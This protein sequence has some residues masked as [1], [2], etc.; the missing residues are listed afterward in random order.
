MRV[1]LSILDARLQLAVYTFLD[2]SRRMRGDARI[3]ENLA[4]ITDE[5]PPPRGSPT[6]GL[7]LL[8]LVVDCLRGGPPAKHSG[9]RLYLL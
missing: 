8:V 6:E 9:V 4:A 1:L 7:H 5:R 3:N 2:K